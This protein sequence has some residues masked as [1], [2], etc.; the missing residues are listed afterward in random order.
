MIDALNLLWIVPLSMM[1]GAALIIVFACIL[2][3]DE[4]RKL[5]EN[6]ECIEN[7]Y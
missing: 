1:T 3:K 4:D 2:I 6:E 7:D 5:R